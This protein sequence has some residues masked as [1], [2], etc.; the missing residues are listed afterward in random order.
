M[1]RIFRTALL[2]IT[3]NVFVA[4]N[5]AAAINS[6]DSDYLKYAKQFIKEKE[7]KVCSFS[8]AE[9]TQNYVLMKNDG[10]RCF[11]L[12]CTHDF[13]SIFSNPVLAYSAESSINRSFGRIQV[14]KSNGDVKIIKYYD[15][16]LNELRG[17]RPLREAAHQIGKSVDKLLGPLQ[18]GQSRVDL[19]ILGMDGFVY[20]GCVPTAATQVMYSYSWPEET[21]GKYLYYVSKDTYCDINMEGMSISWPESLELA[22]GRYFKVPDVFI[23]VNGMVFDATFGKEG[24]S[25]NMRRSKRAFINHYGYSR[26]MRYTYYG[27]N[28]N[29]WK[30]VRSE[31]DASRPVLLAQWGHAFVCDGYKDEYLH[32]NMGWQGYFNGYYRT[33][34]G[35][36]YSVE[37]WTIIDGIVPE[38][39][40]EFVTK[41]VELKEAGTLEQFIT[42][43]DYN[44]LG[45]LV[46][47]GPLNGKDIKLIR[48]LSGAADEFVPFE[49]RGVLKSLD[50]SGA[51]IV[52]SRDVYF[53]HNDNTKLTHDKWLERHEYSNCFVEEVVPDKKYVWNYFTC[54]NQIGCDMFEGCE[55]LE[56]IVL[57]KSIT[58]LYPYCFLNCSSLREIKIPEGVVSFSHSMFM[59][60]SMLQKVYVSK[61]C[62]AMKPEYKNA[63]HDL[64][65]FKNC[66]PDITV[67]EY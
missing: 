18:L 42:A 67:E 8:I 15:N 25:A 65:W 66:R 12:M 60:C 44:S 21:S 29:M 2:S 9:K 32:F 62:K 45:T 7:G 47:S 4:A 56:S 55:N 14:D 30:T 48:M 17:G 16:V 36:G 33:F 57:P 34:V 52:K 26:K 10:N 64:Y 37:G 53:V 59:G 46:V 40:K 11:V 1:I 27:D 5:C 38:K 54:K 43:E 28:E 20:A 39:Q 35:M 3:L 24:T 6:D 50:M 13:D 51:D 61:D 22:R 23:A 31:L 58:S 63:E 49:K 19:S 41:K